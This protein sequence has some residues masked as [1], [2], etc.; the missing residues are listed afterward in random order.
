MSNSLSLQVLLFQGKKKK[1]NKTSVSN[2]FQSMFSVDPQVNT[3]AQT[4][5]T[6]LGI[7]EEKRM[8]TPVIT[9]LITQTKS[10]FY[11]AT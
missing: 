10:A 11:K 1:T 2:H 8:I 3:R 6:A 4:Q 7:R 9:L 5:G